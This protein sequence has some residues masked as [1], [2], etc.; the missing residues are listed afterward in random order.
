LPIAALLDVNAEASLSLSKEIMIS[1]KL[2]IE[3][4]DPPFEI[5]VEAVID[6]INALTF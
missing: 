4:W 3:E 5:N 1:A 6:E 2:V